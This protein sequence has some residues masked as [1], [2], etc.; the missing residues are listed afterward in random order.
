MGKGTLTSLG[1]NPV[2]EIVLQA[3]LGHA[4]SKQKLWRMYR[5]I[6]HRT[7]NAFVSLAPSMTQYKIDLFND[8]MQ[9]FPEV[10]HD[11]DF[12]GDYDFSYFLVKALRKKAS[13]RIKVMYHYPAEL[14]NDEVIENYVEP[15][16]QEYED[17]IYKFRQVMKTVT[18]PQLQ[19]LYYYHYKG[20]FQDAISK[21][22]GISQ[23]GVWKRLERAEWRI[24]KGVRKLEEA[25]IKRRRA[26]R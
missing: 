17:R 1:S 4:E 18:T 3:K 25:T 24:W 23:P 11:Y 12:D 8:L 9:Y 19:A 21:K 22:V 20:V 16:S 5:P 6:V 14:I 7:V 26:S 15:V 13:S 10:V 2:D